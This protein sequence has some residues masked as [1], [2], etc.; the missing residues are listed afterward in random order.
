[1]LPPIAQIVSVLAIPPRERYH[2]GG[3]NVGRDPGTNAPPP[4]ESSTAAL[5][6]FLTATGVCVIALLAFIPLARR[7][8]QIL[9]SRMTD[10]IPTISESGHERRKSI[11]LLA[12]YKKL[13]W[14][15]A[16]VF[17]CF[18]ITMF[19]P[20][21]TSQILSTHNL[22]TSA[23][24]FQP[25]TFIPLAFLLW[26]TG[27]LLGRLISPFLPH[28]MTRR[29]ALMFLASIARLGFLPLYL[30]CNIRGRGAVV[31][32][33]LFYLILV[34]FGFGLSNGVL[35]SGSMM[36]AV[37]SVEEAER[38]AAGGFMGLNLVGGLAAGSLLSFLAASV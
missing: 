15:A 20:V 19:Y 3:E 4:Q 38:E 31:R 26:N 17:S 8:S 36:A 2:G 13:H 33:D 34:Q 18:V 12:L 28:I 29:P 11:P 23:R 9:E 10:S 16:A 24:I 1:V 21:F 14:L 7:H 5:I 6:Y 37:E 25:A 22:D 30:L 27:D 35:G 32:S